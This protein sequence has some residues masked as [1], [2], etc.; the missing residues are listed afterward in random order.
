MWEFEAVGLP[1]LS[2]ELSGLAG[3][4]SSAEAYLALIAPEIGADIRKNFEA[5]GRP[6]RPDP[7]IPA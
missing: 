7:S 2:Q 4:L 1:A 3:E 6:N 5:G